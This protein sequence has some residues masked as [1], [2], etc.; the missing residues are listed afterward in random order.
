MERKETSIGNIPAS[1]FLFIFFLQKEIGDFILIKE[2]IYVAY[3]T[4]LICL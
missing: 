3:L 2:F 1:M 4:A